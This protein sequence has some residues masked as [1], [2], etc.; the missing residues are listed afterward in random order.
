VSSPH[1]LK[2]EIVNRRGGRLLAGYAWNWTKN[3]KNGELAG[4]LSS[5][6]IILL[7][8]GMILIVLTGRFIQNVLTK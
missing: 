3:I 6:S 2:E 8:H 1:E 7:Y 5:R 4:D